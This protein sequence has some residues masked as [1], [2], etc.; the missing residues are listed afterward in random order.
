M[1]YIEIGEKLNNSVDIRIINVL[2]QAISEIWGGRFVYIA[3]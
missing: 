1:V 2:S 3:V